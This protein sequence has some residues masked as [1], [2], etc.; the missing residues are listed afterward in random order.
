MSTPRP[1]P[2]GSR[3]GSA[4][5]TA[6]TVVSG[7][8]RV[9]AAA[10]ELFATK[11]FHGTGIR[12]VAEHAGMR[13]AS[14]Y[15]WFSTKEE[16][17]VRIMTEGNQR[18]CHAARLA[19]VELDEPDTR[20]AAL[21]QVH[22]AVHARDRRSALVVDSEL[23]SLSEPART[24]MMALRDTY[25]RIWQHT[26]EDGVIRRRFN[27]SRPKFARLALIQMCTGVSQWYR[28]DA[29]VPLEQICESFAEMSL[30]LVEA[31][32]GR[33]AVTLSSL[34]MPPAKHFVNLVDEV[35]STTLPELQP[36]DA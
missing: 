30:K 18:L 36:V 20:L 15:H 34:R 4:H 6:P 25:E 8:A 5:G 13:S 21:V 27:V 28:P 24:E 1:V 22:V 26:L 14:L 12:E 19:L 23:R 35:W 9:L 17:L 2:N 11:G 33:R 10:V 29:G 3:P 32:H 31:R 7:Q 16:L